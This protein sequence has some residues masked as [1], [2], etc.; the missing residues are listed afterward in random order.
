LLF[1]IIACLWPF[2]VRQAITDNTKLQR[3][4]SVLDMCEESNL[5]VVLLQE[6]FNSGWCSQLR[7]LLKDA[8]S[9]MTAVEHEEMPCVL[10]RLLETMT[11][12]LIVLTRHTVVE[13]S[14]IHYHVPSSNW[15]N[16][17]RPS[18]FQHVVIEVRGRR[19][20]VLNTHL[21]PDEVND[22]DRE[23]PWFTATMNFLRTVSS[24]LSPT[25]H[26]FMSPREGPPP[27]VPCDQS[28]PQQI[29][30]AQ[31]NQ[32]VRYIRRHVP[33]DEPFVLGGDFNIEASSDEAS[34]LL[35]ALLQGRARAASGENLSEAAARAAAV[36]MKANGRR[37]DEA[38]NAQRGRVASGDGGGGGDACS[39]S[40]G[41]G[42]L[43]LGVSR[44]GSSQPTVHC[45]TPFAIHEPDLRDV[46][47]DHLYSSMRMTSGRVRTDQWHLSDHYPIHV[48]LG[49]PT[50]KQS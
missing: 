30:V 21:F 36:S 15:M 22:V 8:D 7:Q 18:G 37:N 2:A 10:T 29:R 48:T 23:L 5:D 14:F 6:V 44:F 24:Y 17:V 9:P 16:M 40:T 1:H 19:V 47:A 28:T 12:G 13:H 35:D 34:D 49:L 46:A 31:F 27:T 32:I 39:H 38:A 3:L 20:H 41:T 43:N 4:A 25:P 50:K 45:K 26:R 33:G 11:S 42:R